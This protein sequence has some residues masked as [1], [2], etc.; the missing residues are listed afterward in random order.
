MA[1]LVIL[2]EILR[3]LIGTNLG[4]TLVPL[5]KGLAGAL[6]WLLGA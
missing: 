3:M 4:D 5:L 2:S 6:A 1:F